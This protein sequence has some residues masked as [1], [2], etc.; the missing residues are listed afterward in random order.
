MTK[1]IIDISKYVLLV[2]IALYALQS[3]IIFKKKNEDAREFLFLRQNVLMFAIHFIAFTVFYLKMDESTLFYFY[4]AQAIY[5]GAV[6][7]LF[8]NLY[9]RASKLLVNNMCMLITIG[10]IML[11]RISYDQ[12]M[13]QFKILAIATVAAL[14]IPILVKKLKFLDKL[15]YIYALGGIGLLGVVLVFAKFSYGSKLSLSIGGFT[16]QPSEFVKII[17]VFAVA[18]LLAKATD[19]KHVVITTAIAGAHVLILVV[20]KDLGSALIFFVTYLVMLYVGTRDWRY[21]FLGI[22]AGVIASVAA[23]FLFSHVRVRVQVWKDPFAS[24]TGDGYQVA[25]SLFAIGA[26]GWFGTG[27]YQGSPTMIPIV[28]QDFMFSA[29]CEELGGF[30]AICLILIYMS[31]FIM[32]VNIAFKMEN[33][34]ARLASLGL[35]CTF[36]V[37]VFLTVGGAMKMIP[38]T[39]VTLPFISY[40]GSSIMSTV[41]M[42]AIVQ[43]FYISRREERGEYP[44]GEYG[45]YDKY[46]NFYPE[47]DGYAPYGYDENGYPYP[48]PEDGHENG[49]PYEGD[50]YGYPENGYDNGYPYQENGYMPYQQVGYDENFPDPQN[51]G[52]DLYAPDRGYGMNEY[53][54]ETDG[55]EEESNEK[56]RH[57]FSLRRKSR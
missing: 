5:L 11:T 48:Y 46:G 56:E 54:E 43:G 28:E 55:S 53:D 21:L 26:G 1:L 29:I 47:P 35:G 33:K 37:Q 12:S 32:F 19:F 45:Y 42:F 24:Y 49:Y 22:A 34:F 2:L 8:R 23:Y 57:K 18:S 31:C 3:Y 7:V 10:F 36:S 15:G 14:I 44:D 50:G 39:G 13:K 6:L 27:L 17:F 25:Q 30:F 9:P 40:G 52:P 41:I 51:S 4:G 16:F 38:S 20:S